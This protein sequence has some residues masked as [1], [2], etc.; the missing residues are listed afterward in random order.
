MGGYHLGIDV[1]TSRMAA[2]LAGPD[3]RRAPLLVEPSAVCLD[4]APHLAVGRDAIEAGLAHP[5]RFEPYPK[6]AVAQG[7]VLLGGVE[8]PVR[9]L[10]AATL[11]HVAADAHR[12]A[13]MPM[14][15]VT[16]ACPAGWARPRQTM[17]ERA[18]TQVGLH[19]AR[20]VPE[21]VAAA[22]FAEEAGLLSVP[23]GGAVLVCDAGAGAFDATVVRRTGPSFTVAAARSVPDAGGLALDT[24]IA[25]HL[26]AAAA[27]RSVARWKPGR[28]LLDAARTAREELSTAAAAWIPVPWSPSGTTLSRQD[29]ERIAR[30]LLDRA[31]AAVAAV[32]TQ[33]G[34]P[35]TGVVLTGGVSRT[36][37]V[38]ELIE[39]MVEALLG[40]PPVLIEG[41]VVAEG[42]LLADPSLR[43][44]PAVA[45]P[46]PEPAEVAEP[47]ETVVI[48]PERVVATPPMVAA[49][50]E[51]AR[52]AP[53]RVAAAPPMV[54]AP[55]EAVVIAPE[56]VVAVPPEAGR[57]APEP[58]PAGVPR[59]EPG[60]RF[61]PMT[62]EPAAAWGVAASPVPPGAEPGVAAPPRPPA[63]CP[64]AVRPKAGALSRVRRKLTRTGGA[65]H[66][67]AHGHAEAPCGE[68]PPLST[69]AVSP[70]P[71]F[72][73]PSVT[74]A[75]GSAPP[76]AGR[77]NAGSRP[78]GARVPRR[79][80]RTG[81]RLVTA[82]LTLAACLLAAAGGVLV[83]LEV[84]DAVPEDGFR[85]GDC[86]AQDAERATRVD[87]DA[88]N[89]FQ[90]TERLTPADRC[91]DTGQP[92][93][94]QGPALFC[95]APAHSRQ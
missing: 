10:F 76:K 19:R 71:L 21:P 63:P 2:V 59:P 28:S 4:S 5:D 30:P 18:A 31:T 66:W 23:E 24:A 12:V 26:G 48:A 1:G 79:P 36:P 29:F 67:D 55:R 50:P 42:A 90:I 11:S 58:E 91:P 25:G 51:A 85:V 75:D 70:S 82:G 17:L 46:E 56:R 52:T 54:A 72:P 78:G 34:H 13:G 45:A 62:H 77:R 60:P 8:C 37:L 83:A 47:R 44:R 92:F 7:S 88:G 27:S 40:L 74:L 9:N 65:E 32:A 73:T 81:R 20:L 94:V 93:V 22:L 86:V 3:G 95:L 16:I 41:P 14:S 61:V 33:T 64:A 49:P 6:R 43:R 15:T 84:T 39:Q 53:E 38:A 87:C 80:R 35:V 89:A 69:V 68:A 57:T